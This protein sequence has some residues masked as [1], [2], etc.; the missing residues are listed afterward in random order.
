MV[1]VPITVNTQL[2]LPVV[3]CEEAYRIG[4]DRKTSTSLDDDE[5]EEEEEL[6]VVRFPGLL[7]KSPPQQLHYVITFLPPTYKD[8]EDEEE[9]EKDIRRELTALHKC[10]CLDYI[11]RH[12]CSLSCKDHMNGGKCQERKSDCSCPAGWGGILVMKTVPRVPAELAALQN[13]SVWRRTPW[14][15]VPKMVVASA[16][17]VTKA[18]DARKMASGDQSAGSPMCPVKM[19]VSATEKLEVVTALLLTQENQVPYRDAFPL[20]IWLSAGGPA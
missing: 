17:L 4:N 20:P 15:A 18:T 19:E 13:V 11:F 16:N 8:E 12:N 6:E 14:N 2:V 1:V 7:F 5:L 3:P 10:V 9:E